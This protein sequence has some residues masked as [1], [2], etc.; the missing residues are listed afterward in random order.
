MSSSRLS[1]SG[2]VLFPVHPSHPAHRVVLYTATSSGSRVYLLGPHSVSFTKHS[3]SMK[4]P[5][6]QT[7]P[8]T[9]NVI[10]NLLVKA[11]SSRILFVLVPFFLCCDET[12]LPNASVYGTSFSWPSLP[13]LRSLSCV[14]V[15]QNV[16]YT[17]IH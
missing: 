16:P 10:F 17:N 5:C 8:N 6:L 14:S 3:K 4:P 7:L 11:V 1:T 15:I 2:V 13:L 9:H 12:M